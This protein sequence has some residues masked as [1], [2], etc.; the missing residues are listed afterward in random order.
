MQTFHA[1]DIFAPAAAHLSVG[2]KPSDFGPRVHGI[3][4]L[5]P[6]RGVLASDGS[7]IGRIIHIDR[8]G[9]AISTIR[10]EQFSSRDVRFEIGGRTIQGLCRSYADRVGPVA[11]IG[12]SGFLEIAL[13]GRECR[14]EHGPANRRH[15]FGAN[16]IKERQR[17]EP[18]RLPSGD[19]PALSLNTPRGNRVSAP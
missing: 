3:V 18:V 16:L 6:F 2:T 8:F 19:P 4:A 15:A 1:R 13:K 17:Q 10:T 11:L 14:A 7:L 12:S 9:N 5:P